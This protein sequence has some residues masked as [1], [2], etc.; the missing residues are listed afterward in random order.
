MCERAHWKYAPG[1][2]SFKNVLYHPCRGLRTGEGPY[3]YR[4]GPTLARQRAGEMTFRLIWELF[5]NRMLQSVDLRAAPRL[6]HG[7]RRAV[8]ADEKLELSR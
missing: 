1:K 3:W 2:G 8:F 6:K 5:G 7:N 4:G